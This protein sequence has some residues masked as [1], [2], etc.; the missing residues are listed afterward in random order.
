[1]EKT[2]S[3][4]TEYRDN[5]DIDFNGITSFKVQNHG[6]ST[7]DINTIP[8]YPSKTRT[9]VEE[10]GTFCDFK[11]KAIFTEAGKLPKFKVIYMQL[12][13]EAGSTD[14]LHPELYYAVTLY[15]YDRGD[16]VKFSQNISG[17][18]ILTRSLDGGST[19]D[20]ANDIDLGYVSANQAIKYDRGG[21]LDTNAIQFRN[22]DLALDSEIFMVDRF[23][24]DPN[25]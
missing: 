16:V 1:M 18:T 15:S 22:V 2:T 8:V 7:V 25:T 17:H 21:S 24:I 3:H 5:Q 11:L 4:I 10:N 6:E 13:S 20:P 19:F 14:N 12:A 9:F 23:I